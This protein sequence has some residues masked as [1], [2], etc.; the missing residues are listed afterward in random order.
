MF[1][2]EEG[3]VKSPSLFTLIKQRLNSQAPLVH[4][5]KTTLVH[6]SHTLENM[7]LSRRI[8]AIIFT[9]FQESSYWRQEVARYQALAEIAQQV[10]IFSAAPLPLE[11]EAASIH[12]PL[13]RDDPL[14]QEWFLAILSESLAVI[15]CGQDNQ[16]EIT[17]EATRQFETLWSFEPHLINAGLDILEEVVVAY[18]PEKLSQLQEARRSYPVVQTDLALLTEF[19]LHLV[20]FEETLH[21]RYRETEGLLKQ[22]QSH[23]ETEVAQRTEELERYRDHLEDLVIERTAELRAA[24]QNLQHEIVERQR[25]EAERERLL[26]AEQEQR[27]LA[28]TM[29]EVTLVL[30]SQIEPTSVLDEILGQSQ[31]LVPCSALHIMLLQDNILRMARWQGYEAFGCAEYMANLIQPVSKLKM[32]RRVIQTRTALVIPDISQE[33]NWT[34]ISETS[35]I[36]AHLIMPICLQERVLGLLRLDGDTPGQFSEKDAQRLQALSGVAAIALENARLYTETQQR[37]TEQTILRQAITLIS[38]TLDLTGVLNQITEQMGRAVDATSVYLLNYDT[39]TLISTVLADYYSPQANTQERV[40]DLNTSYYMPKEFPMAYEF[41]QSAQPSLVMQVDEA[42]G[43]DTDLVHIRKFG[44]QSTLI[45]RLQAGVE[46]MGYAALWES[47]CRREFTS[48]EIA[49][50]QALAQQAAVALQN[51]QLHEQTRRQARQ[52]EQILNS[53][54]AGLLLL[55]AE[56]Q[57]KMANPAGRIYMSMLADAQ[58][59]QPL[60]QVGNKA[61]EDL[62]VSP[63]HSH[64]H[65]VTPREATQPVFEVTVRPV[66]GE[67]KAEGWVLVVRD[68]TVEREAQ[69]RMQQQEKLAAVGQLAAGIAHD[70]NNILT[71]IIGF[72]ELGLTNPA[73]PD[74]LQRDLAQIVKQGQRAARLVR[75]ILDFARQNI[76]TKR[77]LEFSQFLDDVVKLLER[78]IPETIRL[79]LAIEPDDESYTINADP[80]QLQQVLTN[81]AVNAADAMPSGG[82][83]SFRLSKLALAPGQRPP[84]PGM[85]PGNWLVLA[86]SD[87]GT[88]IPLEAQTHIFEPFFTTK[89]VGQGTGLGLAQV[90]GLIK[91][92]NGYINMDSEVGRGTTFTIFLP[93]L[94][95]SKPVLPAA[96]HEQ[97]SRGAG[98]TILLVEDNLSVLTVISA[99]IERL[100]YQVLTAANGREALELCYQHQAEIAL[101]ITDLAMPEMD[102]LTLAKILQTSHLHPKILAITGYPLKMAQSDLSA[103]GIID[104]LQKPIELELLAYKLEQVLPKKS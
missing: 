7:I 14:C 71:S 69:K 93:M 56:Y 79:E 32:S 47:R 33:P 73:V 90:D 77:S 17:D 28:E 81:L 3:T 101:V 74:F 64:Y 75:Q 65:E 50:V 48:E 15:L 49:L 22:Y 44:G 27:L 20:H 60:T 86:I 63:E 59:G 4:C 6:L 36:Q 1:S 40:S 98:Q 70:F 99:M 54:E 10:C 29:R 51:A 58:P 103:L 12:I 97:K 57:I 91:Q 5:P 96:V 35:W 16:T 62:L 89:E 37:L 9:G 55:D 82:V 87:T 46:L 83:L 2:F 78:T 13:R 30:T 104:W 18:R 42:V 39:E 85:M 76:S 19:T 95:L 26:A 100:G 66:M 34:V 53:V 8:P 80:T 41:L 45:V 52:M 23:L 94:H 31:R 25:A 92:H 38:S 72:A 88:G 24:N 21:Q 61:L 68:V 84:Y 102:G 43:L 67:P 11:S